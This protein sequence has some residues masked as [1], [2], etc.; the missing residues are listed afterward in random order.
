M[1][2]TSIAAFGI[3]LLKGTVPIANINDLSGP[4]LTLDPIDTTTH[5]NSSAWRTFVG[6]LLDAG[7]ISLE[8]DYVPTAASHGNTSGLVNSLSGR[9]TA[10]YSMKF[11]DSAT[12]TWTFTALVTSF[13]P[14]APVDDKLTASVTMKLTGAPT[15]V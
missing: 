3:Q 14:Q 11:P 9:S 12:T 10:S 13:E 6:G 7:E 2:T 8:I 1:S 5:D 15:L 4:G